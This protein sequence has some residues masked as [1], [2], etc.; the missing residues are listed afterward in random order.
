MPLYSCNLNKAQQS[1]GGS[2]TRKRIIFVCAAF[3][4]TLRYQ[5]VVLQM[6]S[7]ETSLL[8]HEASRVVFNV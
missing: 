1:H 7:Y 8:K 6:S 3:V 5:Y 4:Q 2:M